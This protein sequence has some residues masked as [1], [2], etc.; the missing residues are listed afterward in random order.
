[1]NKPLTLLLLAAGIV[2]GRHS[3]AQSYTAPDLRDRMVHEKTMAVLP[4]LA[5]LP[6]T[7][8]QLKSMTPVQIQDMQDSS[9]LSFQRAVYQWFITQGSGNTLEIQD[10]VITDSLLKGAGLSVK[11]VLYGEKTNLAQ[12]LGVDVVLTASLRAKQEY[13]QGGMGATP[14][15][16]FGPDYDIPTLDVF[17]TIDLYD[18]QNGDR[19][20]G[21]EGDRDGGY[22]ARY[23]DQKTIGKL[24][25]NA[26]RTYP[27][28]RK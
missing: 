7:R 9:S 21:Y 13:T 12:I 16:G 17:L 25:K 20:W 18:G 6:P 28:K 11:D 19:L 15:G 23:A 5:P 3:T 24:L 26:Y 2:A 4:A 8:R 1:M 27:Y 22:Y 14:Y 10:P